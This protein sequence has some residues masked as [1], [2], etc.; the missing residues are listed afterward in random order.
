[1]S[2]WHC[3]YKAGFLTLVKGPGHWYNI[4][5]T[6]IIILMVWLTSGIVRMIY[7]VYECIDQST[8]VRIVVPPK[9]RSKYRFQIG[10]L[11]LE[12]TSCIIKTGTGYIYMYMY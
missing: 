6:C 4:L 12:R 3:S 7:Y 9:S 10:V 11:P 1:M 5:T 2:E 8:V